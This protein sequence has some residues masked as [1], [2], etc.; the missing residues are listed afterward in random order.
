MAS[1]VQNRKEFLEIS[2]HLHSVIVSS[3][4]HLQDSMGRCRTSLNIISFQEAITEIKLKSPTSYLNAVRQSKGRFLYRGEDDFQSLS[5]CAIVHPEPDLLSYDTYS[6]DDA[7]I[8]FTYLEK[9]INDLSNRNPNQYFVKPSDGHIGTPSSIEASKWGS[10]FSIWPIGKTF[11]YAYPIGDRKLFFSDDSD[12]THQGG[13]NMHIQH[14]KRDCELDVVHNHGLTNALILGK[15]ILF[16]S[17]D[18]GS[19]Y[20]AVPAHLDHQ[21][22]FCL[23]LE[24]EVAND[25]STF[26]L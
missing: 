16:G 26:N 22:R 6:N 19:S 9:C 11:S 7:L 20:V 17:K 8:Y 5:S 23:S 14:K 3:S 21:L 12:E 1:L 10:P 13:R 15:E 25:F 24:F 2:S 18:C 4:I